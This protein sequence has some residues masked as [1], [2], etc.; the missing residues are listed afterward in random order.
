VVDPAT[1]LGDEQR[2]S[3]LVVP[4]S[5]IRPRGIPAIDHTYRDLIRGQTRGL[6]LHDGF[7]RS[8]LGTADS[9]QPWKAV[10]GSP[11]VVTGYMRGDLGMENIAIAGL[12]HQEGV[13][14]WAQWNTGAEDDVNVG[15]VLRYRDVGNY[16]LCQ[17]LGSTVGPPN[18]GI[19][20]YKRVGGAF[21]LLDTRAFATALS[22]N[23]TLYARVLAAGNIV[24]FHVKLMSSG[25]SGLTVDLGVDSTA[26]WTS[27]QAFRNAWGVGLRFN[28]GALAPATS[29]GRGLVARTF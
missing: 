20:I 4:E 8:G 11:A 17:I 23:V 22:S 26:L 12:G 9:G 27:G 15:F 10:A 19:K 7:Q 18:G 6:L 1:P 25:S 28:E 29:T 21:T 2:P 14:M 16:I 24:F 13:E 3:G 5:G